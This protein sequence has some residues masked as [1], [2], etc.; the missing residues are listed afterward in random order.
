[1]K[2]KRIEKNKT[3]ASSLLSVSFASLLPPGKNST[4]IDSLPERSVERLERLASRAIRRILRRIINARRGGPPVLG[5]HVEVPDDEELEEDVKETKSV[6]TPVKAIH[7]NGDQLRPITKEPSGIDEVD[8]RAAEATKEANMTL[9]SANLSSTHDAATFSSGSVS[10]SLGSQ[11]SNTK[12]KRR[13]PEF[14]EREPSPSKK[15]CEEE[16]NPPPEGSELLATP[17]SNTNSTQE[18]QTQDQDRELDPGHARTRIY[19]PYVA[20]L[21]SILNPRTRVINLRQLEQLRESDGA[22]DEE[23]NE[24]NTSAHRSRDGDAHS[25]S[26]EQ[27]EQE[28]EEHEVSVGDDEGEEADGRGRRKKKF[29][30][31]P[32]SYTYRDEMYC[33]LKNELDVPEFFAHRIMAVI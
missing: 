32:Q 26:E 16:S 23:D 19:S 5:R 3:S 25:Q 18:A 27:D 1:M 15:R 20:L 28:N 21:A 14:D 13:E 17:V 6:D 10:S 8:Y 33:I 31:V 4:K 22:S 7:T 29:E 2:I 9:D 11:A 12:N 24:G 30:W